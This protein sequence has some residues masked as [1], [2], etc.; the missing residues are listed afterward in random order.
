MTVILCICEWRS[1][2]TARRILALRHNAS[3][4]DLG[5]RVRAHVQYVLVAL[6][7]L[8]GDVKRDYGSF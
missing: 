1:Q 4:E 6:V 5:T 7:Y 3:W 8:L 2:T